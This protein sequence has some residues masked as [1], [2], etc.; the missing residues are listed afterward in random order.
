MMRSPLL[1]QGLVLLRSRRFEVQ[2]EIDEFALRSR[3]ARRFEQLCGDHFV[4]LR[5][6][7]SYAY[8][9]VLHSFA[10]FTLCTVLPAVQCILRTACSSLFAVGN[11]CFM[12]LSDQCHG[13]LSCDSL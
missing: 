7:T 2:K 1:L 5:I 4:A 10:C 11:G 6:Y 3:E 12:R 9:L 13:W 8:L